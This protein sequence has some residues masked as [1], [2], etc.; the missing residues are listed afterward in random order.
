MSEIITSTL[1]FSTGRGRNERPLTSE[2]SATFAPMPSAERRSPDDRCDDGCRAKGTQCE[3]DVLHTRPPP[4][5]P[6][7]KGT[8][9][10]G[11]GDTRRT[12]IS[13]ERS[14]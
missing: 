2:N 7:M 11:D 8:L 14:V 12:E 13:C 5:L 6:V 3:T 10:G 1:G 9:Y 4:T